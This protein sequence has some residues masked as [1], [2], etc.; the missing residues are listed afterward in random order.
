MRRAVERRREPV[1]TWV[2][3]FRAK[4]GR[5]AWVEPPEEMRW[6]TRGGAQI[7]GRYNPILRARA[8]EVR[9]AKTVA[10]TL[11]VIW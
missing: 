5:V 2:Q 4:L 8:L 6:V 9:E 7:R 1:E 10:Q 11:E 3:R